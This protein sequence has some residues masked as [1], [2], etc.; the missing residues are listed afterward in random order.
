MISNELL[1]KRIAI[2]LYEYFIRECLEKYHCFNLEMDE[3][4]YKNVLKKTQTVIKNYNN[5]KARR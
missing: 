5:S 1:K 4:L 2:V 3:V